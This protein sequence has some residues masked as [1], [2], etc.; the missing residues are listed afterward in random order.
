MKK[1]IIITGM[2][3][4][5]CVARVKELFEEETKVRAVDVTLED[6]VV[7]LD[8]DLSNEE[9]VYVLGEDYSIVSI[10]CVI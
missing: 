2:N 9:I 8:S 1:K 4:G 5:H 10:D 7:L 3:C 6:G